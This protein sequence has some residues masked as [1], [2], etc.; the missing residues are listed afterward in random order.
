MIHTANGR[1]VNNSNDL[2][3]E[4]DGDMKPSVRDTSQ[5]NSAAGYNDNLD[6]IED[7]GNCDKEEQE[8]ASNST[9]SFNDIDSIEELDDCDEDEKAKI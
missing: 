3:L 9:A 1:F 8:E 2:L 5:S 4:N 7:L 6:S